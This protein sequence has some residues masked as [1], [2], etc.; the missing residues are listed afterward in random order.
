[1]QHTK[2]EPELTPDAPASDTSCPAPARFWAA[3]LGGDSWNSD[4]AGTYR[5]VLSAASLRSRS[6][7]QPAQRPGL[8]HPPKRLFRTNPKAT[9]S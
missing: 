4:D 5:S 1:M 3:I 8:T 9:R 6:A 7:R 2:R